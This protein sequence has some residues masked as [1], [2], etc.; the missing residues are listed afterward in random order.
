MGDERTGA[1]AAR[2][3]AGRP[4]AER[5]E[6]EVRARVERLAARGIAPH[7]AILRVGERA[8]DIAYE[9]MALKKCES[10]GV[11]SS[12]HAL[13][14]DISEADYVNSL[15]RLGRDESVHCILPFRPLPAQ[16][17]PH[18][19]KEHLAPAKDGDCITPASSASI[20]DRSVEA[21][22]PCTAEAVVVLLRHYEIPL[23]G[24]NVVIIGR[25][26]V[27]GRALALLLLDED[28]TVTV[29]HSKTRDLS[30]V[31]TRAD[32]VVAAMGRARFVDASFVKPEAVVIDVGV[33][34]DGAGGI[35]GDVDAESVLAS[36]VSAYTPVPGGVGSITSALLVRNVVTA[37]ER[38]TGA[39]K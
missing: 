25:S 19:L 14:P 26:M 37:C 11:R 3:L 10:L 17:S 5:I 4:V 15:A 7:L 20:Y 32:I 27:V 39:S 9:R 24:A 29:C 1:S 12:V 33:N 2:R 38:L 18:C 28:A 13:P 34:D 31:S 16:I 22:L 30:D 8:D 23:R 36:G 35:C 21:F 6:R